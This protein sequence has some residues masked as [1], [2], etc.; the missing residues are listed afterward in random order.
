MTP[1][2]P[3]RNREA[4]ALARLLGRLA[5]TDLPLLLEGETGTGK[6]FVAVR[7][8]RLTRR[9]R[10]YVVVDCGA[11]PETLFAAELFGHVAGAFTDSGPARAGWLARAAHGTLVL[12]RVEVLPLAAQL[13]LLRVLE[14]RR[15]RPLGGA[16]AKALRAR[17]IALAGAEL[18]RRR[19]EGAFRDDFYH[20]LAG[21]HVVLPPLR[22]R[23][24][25][26]VPTARRFLA[27]QRRALRRELSLDAEAEDLLESLPWPGNFRQLHAAMVR[28]ALR[29]PGGR[30]GVGEFGDQDLAMREAEELASQRLETVREIARAHALRVLARCEGNASRAAR[31]L[32]VSRRTLIRWRAPR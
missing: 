29:A 19:A 18:A 24:E 2:F 21:Y 3:S 12:D 16:T 5:R 14:E 15:Y 27:E 17:V 6:S 1:I 30:V 31:I 4:A 7:I 10:P 25:D 26:I 8:H 9:Q 22:S 28:A 11:V 32:G 23:R 20:R 13:A